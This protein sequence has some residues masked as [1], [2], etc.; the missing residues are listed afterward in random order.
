MSDID[1]RIRAI[2]HRQ[3]GVLGEFLDHVFTE[4]SNA[5]EMV[6]FDKCLSSYLHDRRQIEF[7]ERIFTSTVSLK[8]E[9]DR[10]RLCCNRLIIIED[11]RNSLG[12]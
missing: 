3:E 8:K 12:A 11:E 10:F 1:E 5:S 2:L 9:L 6:K 7:F 4:A